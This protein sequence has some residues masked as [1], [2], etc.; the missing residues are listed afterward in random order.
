M[1]TGYQEAVEKPLVKNPAN[2]NLF[3]DNVFKIIYK[4]AQLQVKVFIMDRKLNA[5]INFYGYWFYTYFASVCP[6]SRRTC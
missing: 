3:L 2:M 4:L 5:N 1:K 6:L